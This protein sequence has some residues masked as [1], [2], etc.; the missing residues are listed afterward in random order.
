MTK[1]KI[2]VLSITTILFL[3][4]ISYQLLYKNFQ[5]N[6]LIQEINQN[7]GN[8]DVQ[9]ISQVEETGIFVDVGGE[10]KNP[11]LYELKGN[12]RVNDA[13]L[14]AGG[15][16][17]NAD[18]EVVNLAY[19]LS[20]EMKIIIPSK[21]AKQENENITVHK[22]VISSGITVVEENNY[23]N[24]NGKIN[25]NKAGKKDLESLTGIGS[26]I[27]ERI[28]DYR[29]SNG[30]FNKIEEIKNVSGIGDA[31]YSAIKDEITV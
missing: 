25:I 9:P 10:V 18:M 19:I 22:E 29:K 17:G 30:N 11:G 16:T 20:D 24:S 23:G 21:A 2:I 14:A 28:I 12:A 5:K 27:A 4:A 13:I 6:E 15:V 7:E 8:I 26:S 3:S 1:R 31:K